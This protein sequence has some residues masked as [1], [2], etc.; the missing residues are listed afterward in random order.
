MYEFTDEDSADYIYLSK[1]IL[2]PKIFDD[3][4]KISFC[5]CARLS[6]VCMNYAL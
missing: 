2:P 3:L 4:V 6:F 5:I 1:N